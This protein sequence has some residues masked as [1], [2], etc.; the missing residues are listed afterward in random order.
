LFR[1][2]LQTIGLKLFLIGLPLL[3]HVSSFFFRQLFS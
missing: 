2:A 3:L 1:A